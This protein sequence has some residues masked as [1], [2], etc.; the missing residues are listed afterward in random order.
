METDVNSQ[1]C[2]TNICVRSDPPTWFFN[3]H[4]G[5][6]VLCNILIGRELNQI[7]A[8]NCIY[9]LTHQFYVLGAQKNRLIET[10][11]LGT[12]NICFG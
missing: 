2:A 11:L 5:K 6:I 8:Y 3:L 7:S 10:V 4:R 12:H 9:F 1:E